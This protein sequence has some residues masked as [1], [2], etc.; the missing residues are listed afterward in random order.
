ML[1]ALQAYS[2]QSGNDTSAFS[3]ILAI[4]MIVGMWMI[5]VK[6]DR[7]GWYALIPFYNYYKLFE[8]V[9]GRGILFL[10]MAIPLVGP[11]VL[12]YYLSKAFGKEGAYVLGLMLLPSIFYLVLG[13]G[14]STY[15]GP[16]GMGDTR[17]AEAREAKTV[18]FDVQPNKPEESTVSFDVE[19][20]EDA[21]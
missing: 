7:P 14:D 11:I 4:A 10:V 8:A 1:A 18:N 17:T 19:Q 16:M 3:G 21:E 5:F 9:S 13:F 2:S 20:S 12:G 6:M 15:Y